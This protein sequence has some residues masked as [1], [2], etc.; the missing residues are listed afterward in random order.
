MRAP[1]DAATLK[2]M[3]HGVSTAVGLSGVRYSADARPV[4]LGSWKTTF[5]G[6]IFKLLIAALALSLPLLA[7]RPLPMWVGGMLL[8][9]GLA[10]L[11]VGWTARHSVV[12]K[13]AFGSGTMTVIAG[14]F[15]M[16]AVGMG[17]PQL[18]VLTIAW[19][20]ARG[21]ISGVL[22]FNWRSSRAAR[23]LLLLRGAADLILALALLAGVSVAQIAFILFGGT[24]A[25]V[26]GFLVIVA[27]SFGI[28]GVGLV[29][30]A[31]A[32]R[33]WEQRQSAKR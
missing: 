19:L 16:G 5:A 2:R 23:M 10:E 11:A 29:A 30:I 4:P 17:L 18:T 7:N 33:A 32:E 6:G 8:A 21:L 13:V 28:A 9:G 26:I 24:P 1:P 14:L 27:I 25:M 22:A 12:G 31:I 15:F 3:E 20:A